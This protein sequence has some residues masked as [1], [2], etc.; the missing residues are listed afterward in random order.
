M[1]LYIGNKNYSSWSLRPWIAMRSAGIAFEEEI[2]WL[3]RPDTAAAIARVSPSGKVP[4]LVDGDCV[5][6]ESIAILEYVA[7]RAPSLWPE[8]PRARAVAR[9]VSA[10][11]HAGFA[12][13]RTACPMDIARAPQAIPLTADV[14]ANV[15]RIVAIW[16]DCR[17]RFGAGGDFLFGRQFCNADAMFA[18]VVNRFHAYAIE[19]PPVVRAYIDAVMATPAWR[20]WET[21]ARLEPSLVAP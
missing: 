8:D 15:D 11:M 14:R 12:P 20:E 7:E 5:M 9:A 21:A 13:L 1:K 6:P 3:R 19:V 2:V 10:E 4:V 17:A 18:P 16:T